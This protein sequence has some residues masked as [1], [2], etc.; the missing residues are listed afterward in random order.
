MSVCRENL[1]ESCM[2]SKQR[3]PND[4]PGQAS[5]AQA[6]RAV[7]R[8]PRVAIP[9]PANEPVPSAAPG[10]NPAGAALAAVPQPL[11]HR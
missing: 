2:I 6:A 7:P 5:R 3:A 9:E 8:A 1:C 4:L 10:P 11:L